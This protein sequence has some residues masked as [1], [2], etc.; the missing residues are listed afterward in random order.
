MLLIPLLLQAVV[1]DVV[2]DVVVVTK[3]HFSW[4]ET[5]T[6]RKDSGILARRAINSAV[7]FLQQEVMTV[8]MMD[9]GCCYCCM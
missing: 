1:A 7:L 8:A 5:T 4:C 2:A 9:D 3:Q 6:P